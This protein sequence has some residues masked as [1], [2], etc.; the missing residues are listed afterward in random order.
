MQKLT[1]RLFETKANNKYPF[2]EYDYDYS[3]T[4]FNKSTDKI[5]VYCNKHKLEFTSTSASH[6]L[7][8]RICPKCKK[9]LQKPKKEQ[10]QLDKHNDFINRCKQKGLDK[11]Y[12]LSKIHYINERTQI[13]T[14]CLRCGKDLDPIYPFNFLNNNCGCSECNKNQRLLI[15]QNK[16]I[17]QA[18]QIHVDENGNSKF[19][20]KNVKYIRQ[21]DDVEIYCNRHKIYF[22]QSP[23]RHLSSKY[24]CPL[25]EKEF[26][27]SNKLTT[28]E[29]VKRAQQIYVD[30]NG[31]PKYDYSITE[32]FGAQYYLD[33]ICPIHG[34]K[35]QKAETHLQG[36]GCDECGRITNSLKQLKSPEQFIKES[37][38]IHDPIRDML[39]L[40]RYIYDKINYQ[41]S[42]IPVDIYCPLHG[43]FKQA[44]YGHL[45]KQ[46]CPLCDNSHT[47]KPEKEI[48][49][50]I[51]SIYSGEI[52]ENDRKILSPKE[53]DIYLPKKK[54]A[55]EFDGFYYHSGKVKPNNY[56]YQK[57]IA[58]ENKGIQLIHIFESE[59][60]N[61]KEIVKSRI[62][63]ILGKTKY[64]LR[65]NKCYIK[66][67]SIEEEKVF[68]ENQHL[69]GYTVS[70]LCYGLYYY[71]K[72][73]NKEYLVSLMSFGKPR[74][75]KEYEWEILRFCN[76]RNFN[77]YGSASK[78]F[79]YFIKQIN[80]KSIISYA[81]RKWSI[82][83]ENNLY[84]KL[85]FEL[86]KTNGFGYWY[87]DR[88]HLVH[89]SK[90]TK[91][92]CKKLGCPDNMT[93]KEF[94]TNV[95]GLN[96]I[97]DCG[98]LKYIWNS[99]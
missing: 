40:P 37:K 90:Y 44:P 60:E 3:K 61:S 11:L 95:L 45:T 84:S 23:V 72:Q 89:R 49:Q 25:C 69:Q 1:K 78:L 22:K 97:Y 73:N 31:N 21:E 67:V 27:K 20:Y 96:I 66:Q 7:N 39:G 62:S 5:N 79:Q 34:V 43:Y 75:E 59:W 41:G 83:S 68:L 38:Q 28:E 51:K 63:N 24:C 54:I 18:Q 26:K 64:K 48:V 91:E 55:I 29:F 12:D 4:F 19:D 56:H 46:G 47:S 32:Y 53:L 13:V 99:K 93:E 42:Y 30:E 50:F 65:A 2:P 52:I 14:S 58:C 15:E 98:Q 8:G 33:Y 88:K 9:E 94:V 10:K 74:Y 36:H 81:D 16:F 77:I 6:F 70:S 86:I 71:N 85:G 57:T 76:L 92:K 17:H 87:I 82:H 80:P 35:S